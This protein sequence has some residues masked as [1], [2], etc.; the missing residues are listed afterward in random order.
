[1]QHNAEAWRDTETLKEWDEIFMK[2]G[3]QWSEFWQLPYWDP[4]QML[5]IDTMHCILEGLVY[6]HCCHVLGLST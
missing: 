6:Y 5:V 4:M 2:Q 1:M 3:V